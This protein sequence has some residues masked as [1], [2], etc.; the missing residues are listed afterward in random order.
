MLNETLLGVNPLYLLARLGGFEPPT[1]GLEVLRPGHPGP[2]WDAEGHCIF[3]ELPD[4]RHLGTPWDKPGKGG[5]LLVL[6]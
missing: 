4:S 3:N 2:P 5:L 1:D 6:C